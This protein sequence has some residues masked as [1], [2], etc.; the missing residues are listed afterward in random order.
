MR[1][2]SLMREKERR[3]TQRAGQEGSPGLVS[4]FESDG[5]LYSGK[6]LLLLRSFVAA[7]IEPGPLVL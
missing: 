2:L 3:G 1:P 6:V 5:G 7:G 4:T